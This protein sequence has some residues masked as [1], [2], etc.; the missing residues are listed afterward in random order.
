M[1]NTLNIILIITPFQYYTILF[2]NNSYIILKIT[3]I[4]A[5][6]N[7][8]IFEI[9]YIFPNIKNDGNFDDTYIFPPPDKKDNDNVEDKGKDDRH[10]SAGRDGRNSGNS[11]GSSIEDRDNDDVGNSGGSSIEDRDNDDDVVDAVT[12][13]PDNKTTNDFGP[14]S[15][16]ES[17]NNGTNRMTSQQPKKDIEDSFQID[18]QNIQSLNQTVSNDMNQTAEQQQQAIDQ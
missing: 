13:E 16:S 12:N 9:D 2:E 6:D 4:Y 8:N 17:P 5:Q 18:Q 10:D 15:S 1:I 7:K 11:G 14:L 3:P